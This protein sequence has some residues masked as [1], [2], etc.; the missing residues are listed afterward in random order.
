MPDRRLP[1]SYFSRL[2]GG[3]DLPGRNRKSNVSCRDNLS[4][5][6]L[7]VGNLS[8]NGMSGRNLG[9]LPCSDN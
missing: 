5:Q 7:S 6:H 4:E 3:N 2:S 9:G 1:G 8:V